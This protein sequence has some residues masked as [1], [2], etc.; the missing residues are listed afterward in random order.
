MQHQVPTR[1]ESFSS[2]TASTAARIAA[3]SRRAV[4]RNQFWVHVHPAAAVAAGSFTA[5]RR[6]PFADCQPIVANPVC[7]YPLPTALGLHG[8]HFAW[9][10]MTRD[11]RRGSDDRRS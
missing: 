7:C 9:P 10:G 11:S 6:P 4:V 3:R 2:A 1:I 5:C 8:V